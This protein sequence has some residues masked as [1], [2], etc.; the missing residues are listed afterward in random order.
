MTE[1]HLNESFI[2]V[3]VRKVPFRVPQRWPPGLAPYRR[4]LGKVVRRH[5]CPLQ[6]FTAMEICGRL[7]VVT[8]NHHYEHT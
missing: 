3:S 7:L 4:Q 5:Q 8:L 2:V 1:L 6:D